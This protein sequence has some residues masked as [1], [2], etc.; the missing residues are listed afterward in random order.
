[1]LEQ[2]DFKFWL[3]LPEN[4]PPTVEFAKNTGVRYELVAALCYRQKG[5]VFKKESAPILKISEPLRILK[6]E[7]HSAWPLYSVPDTRSVPGANGDVKMTVSRPSSAFGPTD[8]ILL[9]GSLKSTRAKTFKFKGFE[10]ILHE[11]LTTI[12]TPPNPASI[13]NKKTKPP[14]QPVTKSKVIC[15]QKFPVDENMP[16]GAEK[17]SRMDMAIPADKLLVT[18]RNARLFNLT[19]ELEVRA[20]CDSGIQDIKIGNIKYVV[21]PFARSHAQQAVR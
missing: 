17:S 14:A 4:I 15:S 20:V 2:A 16:N 13:K 19:Y 3:P 12:P 11:T 18:V 6:H 8:R 9:T 1:M 7:L 5:G 10:C 21:G